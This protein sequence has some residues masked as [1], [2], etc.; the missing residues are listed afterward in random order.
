MAPRLSGRSAREP[1]HPVDHPPTV[2]QL[3]VDAVLDGPGRI[4]R[5]HLNDAP[6]LDVEGVVQLSGVR[7]AGLVQLDVPVRYPV[8]T[9]SSETGTGG[10][11]WGTL[12]DLVRSRTEGGVT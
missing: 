9:G 10:L 8:D 1:V 2:H 6:L 3:E 4:R 12:C 11:I 5:E 7:G